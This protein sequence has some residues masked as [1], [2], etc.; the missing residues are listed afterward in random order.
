MSAGWWLRRGVCGVLG[1]SVAP[2]AA[3]AAAAPAA[4]AG[5]RE[6]IV[7]EQVT[8]FARRESRF[9]PLADSV[10]GHP[11]V[12]TRINLDNTVDVAYL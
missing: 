12:V 5:E 1:L 10:T 9:A 6:W 8:M 11:A 7:G 3:A 4:L 2:R